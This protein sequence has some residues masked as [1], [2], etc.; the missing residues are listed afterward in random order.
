MKFRTNYF[1]MPK[2]QGKLII[3]SLIP[4]SMSLGLIWFARHMTNM[5][6]NKHLIASGLGRDTNLTNLIYSQERIFE[7]YFMY[8]C[9]ISLLFTAVMITIFSHQ[10]AGPIYRL[11]KHL[12]ENKKDFNNIKFRSKDGFEE[13]ETDLNFYIEKAGSVA[14]KDTKKSA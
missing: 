5:K 4:V 11:K 8:G 14:N 6:I 7:S 9:I 12:K 13:I 10:L 2:Y 1:I 3:A